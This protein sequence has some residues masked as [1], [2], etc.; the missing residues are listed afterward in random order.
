MENI[1][2][3][4]EEIRTE[5]FWAECSNCTARFMATESTCGAMQ[6]IEPCFCGSTNYEFVKPLSKEEQEKINTTLKKIEERRL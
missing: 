6:V 5:T 1:T 4:D 2:G 3:V